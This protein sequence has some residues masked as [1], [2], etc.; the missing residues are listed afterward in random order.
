M[1]IL[2]GLLCDDGVVIGADSVATST[3]GFAPTIEQ[4][5]EKKIEVIQDRVIVATTG[6][7]GL[8]QRFIY[9]VNQLWNEKCITGNPETIMTLIS[10]EAI[11]D[12]NSTISPIQRQRGW[13]LGALV[14]FP[15]GVKPFLIEFDSIHFHPELKTK[16][17]CFVS[18]GCGQPIADP[19][20]GFLRRVFANDDKVLPPLSLGKFAV[21]WT[22]RHTINLNTG[23]IGGKPYI[24]VLE[25]GKKG[26]FTSRLLTEDEIGEQEQ[27]VDNIEGYLSQYKLQRTSSEIF[28]PIPK[29][30]S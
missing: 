29:P 4:P 13:G 7:V 5:Y 24:A 3:A 20:L 8:A 1:T 26:A 9:L 17:I 30:I 14:A 22:L 19:F 25:R 12:F 10:R 2:I 23:G 21:N 18:M 27:H 6:A 28:F 16:E 15:L 11:K